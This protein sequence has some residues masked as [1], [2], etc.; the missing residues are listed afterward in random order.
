MSTATT[1]PQSSPPLA[2]SNGRRRRWLLAGVLAL[3]AILLIGWG[4]WWNTVGQFS[5]S[6]DDAYVGGNVVQVTPQIAGA[7]LA[8]GADDM[9]FVRAGQPLVELDTAESRVALDSA[10]AGL[11]RAVRQVRNLMALTAGLEATVTQRRAEAAKAREDLGR[12]EQFAASGA[13]SLEEIQHARDALAAGQAALIAA[14]QALAAHRTLIDRTTLEK[15]PDVALAAAR[16]REVYLAHARTSL[17]APVAGFVAKRN[18]QV[19]QRVAP[20]MPLMTVVAL[21]QVWVDANFKERQLANLRVGQPAT[22]VADLYGSSVEYRGK[23]AG[24]S[25]GT[26]G[27][28]ALLPPQNAS[29][30]WIKIVQRVPVRIALDAQE[31]A[32]HPLQLGLSMRVEVDTHERSGERLPRNIRDRDSHAYKTAAFNSHEALAAQRIAAI[33]AANSATSGA[34]A[35]P[36]SPP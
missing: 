27:A 9:E 1:A 11:A 12:R 17:P 26:G 24:F 32:R 4:L 28:F 36:A 23:V 33:I 6:T 14:E 13:V 7:V 29:G 2:T 19:G 21:D 34:V 35:Q 20:G 18:V 16:L 31:L 30:N 8:I 10:E 3:I 15:H 5:E 25:A 22:V